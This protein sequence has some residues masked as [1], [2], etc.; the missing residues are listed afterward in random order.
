MA[1]CRWGCSLIIAVIH[2][3]VLTLIPSSSDTSSD[4]EEGGD[5]GAM[6]RDLDVTSQAL[7]KESRETERLQL[8]L[9]AVETALDVVD[10]ETTV[11]EAVAME[12]QAQLAEEEEASMEENRLRA[13]LSAMMANIEGV[14]KTFEHQRQQLD[15]MAL[16]LEENKRLQS[17]VND[18]KARL[19]KVR[20]REEDL[21]V[22]VLA[23][24]KDHQVLESENRSLITWL[25]QQKVLEMELNISREAIA[26]LQKE[27]EEAEEKAKKV[28]ADL[29]QYRYNAQE[30]FQ[31]FKE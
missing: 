8:C 26:Q 3:P 9:S 5:I 30:Q 2:G 15:E 28:T 14:M 25:D 10:R 7:H 11:A 20:H 16:V 31:V 22:K 18:L 29:E 1:S 4:E 19:T 12:A 23:L 17:L 6:V 24:E 13:D 21:E 27:K